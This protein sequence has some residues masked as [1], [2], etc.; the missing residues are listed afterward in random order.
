MQHLPIYLVMALVLVCTNSMAAQ[1]VSNSSGA[2]EA[3]VLENFLQKVQNAA[4]R[5]DYVGTYVHQQGEQV[6]S[7]KLTHR[8]D[9]EGEQERLELLDGEPR[10]FLRKNEELHCY[11]PNQ[12]LLMIERQ[13]MRDRFPAL[14]SRS[15]A[16]AAKHYD[17]QSLG[18]QRIAGRACE[19]YML[20]PKDAQRFGYRLCS[21]NETG[22]LIKLQTLNAS[23]Q[24]IEQIA[25][26]QIDLSHAINDRA[27]KIPWRTN[28]WKTV[29]QAQ[30]SS[31][32]ATTADADNL[33]D[34][35]WRWPNLPAGFESIKELTRRFQKSQR[36]VRQL[37]LSDGL[38]TVSVFIE[39]DL[40]EQPDLVDDARIRGALHIVTRRYGNFRLTVVGETPVTT[41]EQIA[42]AFI[43]VKP[44]PVSS[45]PSP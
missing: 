22:L 16:V 1:P 34:A 23:Q 14:L 7:A 40:P 5:L 28:N 35:G 13:P 8:F 2:S 41:L 9:S 4:L 20:K 42:Q 24:I 17:L 10:E 15:P 18:R 27:F 25:F 29:N 43:L 44:Q 31:G 11:L 39:P 19:L 30:E 36:S 45:I 32:S 3:A 38:A 26:T 21:D 6:H 12:R 33:T 37:M